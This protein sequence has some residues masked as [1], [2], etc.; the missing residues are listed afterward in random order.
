MRRQPTVDQ[1]LNLPIKSKNKKNNSK[2][3]G[4]YESTK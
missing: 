2:Q 1:I 4:S 3:L